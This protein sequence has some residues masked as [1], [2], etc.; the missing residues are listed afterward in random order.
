MGHA[1]QKL[2]APQAGELPLRD[3]DPYRV[4]AF[5]RFRILTVL[6]CSLFMVGVRAC[7]AAARQ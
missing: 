3:S 6:G 2:H 5:P 7:L 4:M 1:W